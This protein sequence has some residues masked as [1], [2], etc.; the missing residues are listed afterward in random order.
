MQLQQSLEQLMG[1]SSHDQRLPSK[2][3]PGRDVYEYSVGQNMSTMPL[4]VQK[5]APQ[6]FRVFEK[7][8]NTVVTALAKSSF[9]KIKANSF[10]NI[11]EDPVL[12]PGM[13]SWSPGFPS[14]AAACSGR[15][16]SSRM[17]GGVAGYTLERASCGIFKAAQYKV[18]MK[19]MAGDRLTLAFKLRAPPSAV[20][21]L[22][23]G[24][25]L[26]VKSGL[27]P[28]YAGPIT[29]AKLMWWLDQSHTPSDAS[30]AATHNCYNLVSQPD[31]KL[32]VGHAVAS[33]S[34]ARQAHA[35]YV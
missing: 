33:T 14:K 23:P 20:I 13:V 7:T 15:H 5:T 19:R 28:M 32:D 6:A 27:D 3:F 30:T 21:N 31:G 34:T 24:L 26:D 12:D 1:V 18:D 35:D 2:Q 4:S 10:D 29:T 22:H 9:L 25:P 16:H 11:L 8:A 17:R